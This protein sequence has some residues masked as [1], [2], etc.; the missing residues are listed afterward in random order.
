MKP[1][2]PGR[3]RAGEPI[4][5]VSPRRWDPAQRTAAEQLDQGEPGWC[6]FYGIG[7]RRFVAIAV[8]GVLSPLRVEASTVE[9]LREQ[10][11]EAELGAMASIGR[12]W[13]WVA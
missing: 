13:A 11:R 1:R 6:I 7:I 5:R 4:A 8:W 12:D 9:D 3:H 10:M 2:T